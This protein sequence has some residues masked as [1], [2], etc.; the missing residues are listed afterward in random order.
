[1]VSN[2]VQSHWFA[3]C[4]NLWTRKMMQV[5]DATMTKT[6][7]TVCLFRDRVVSTCFLFHVVAL[8]MSEGIH[9]SAV[10]IS[11]A[12]L[13]LE[14]I[15]CKHPQGESKI[16]MFQKT[17][18]VFSRPFLRQENYFHSLILLFYYLKDYLMAL[19]KYS[20]QTICKWE[21]HSFP[22]V[23]RNILQ[24]VGFCFLKSY[25]Q[26][27]RGTSA[28]T[29]RNFFDIKQFEQRILQC[30]LRCFSSG[31]IAAFCIF[32]VWYRRTTMDW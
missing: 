13:I 19:K 32:Q 12:L 24:L 29:P 11:N 21:N 23:L 4:E 1:M 25:K 9:W 8:K 14:D 2:C 18:C 5:P 6:V 20:N 15:A 26:K 22:W 17:P 28:I 10:F 30:R 3:L 31:A 7:S 16:G 27:L